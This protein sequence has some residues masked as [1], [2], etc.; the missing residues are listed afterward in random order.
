MSE[1]KIFECIKKLSLIGAFQKN[2]NVRF[3]QLSL[4][5][6]IFI[7]NFVKYIHIYKMK[8]VVHEIL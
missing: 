8:I 7:Y 6:L 4:I 5:N 2:I 1:N 3:N